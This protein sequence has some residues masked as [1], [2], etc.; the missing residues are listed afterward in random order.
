[1]LIWS[2]RK[3]A[4][5]VTGTDATTLLIIKQGRLRGCG[6]KRC[7]DLLQHGAMEGASIVPRLLSAATIRRRASRR[8]VPRTP[9]A[10]DR[11]EAS[12]GSS[13]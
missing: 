10:C 2:P 4:C 13:Q 3:I 7:T 5:S 12:S 11:F 1:M 9:S 6:R 8:R